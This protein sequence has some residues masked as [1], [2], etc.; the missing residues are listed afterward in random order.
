MVRNIFGSIGIS[1]ASA[2]V[3]ERT[4]VHQSYLAQWA[5]PFHQPFNELIAHYERTLMTMGYAVSAVHDEAVRRVYQLYRAQAEVFAYSDVFL[6]TAVVA[7][8]VVPF[9]LILSSA[10]GGGRAAMD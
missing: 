7:F 8:A 5:S 2:M 1:V 6:F 3:I 10:K 9:C 4:Q